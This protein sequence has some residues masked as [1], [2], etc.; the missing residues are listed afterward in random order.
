MKITNAL[1]KSYKIHLKSSKKVDE[2]IQYL[3]DE[4]KNNNYLIPLP[5]P[6]WIK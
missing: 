1:D 4:K 5:I 2:L 3:E 6:E